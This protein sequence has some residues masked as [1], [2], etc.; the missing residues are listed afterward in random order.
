MVP[1]KD[2]GALYE[3]KRTIKFYDS[4][5]IM[6]A[7]IRYAQTG[8]YTPGHKVG[9]RDEELYFKVV[10]TTHPPTSK[11]T[12]APCHLYY[13]S[14]EQWEKHFKVSCPDKIKND[15]REKYNRA[16][17]RRMRAYEKQQA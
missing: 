6:G 14:P 4:S 1:D 12:H 17:Y 11:G 15:W 7:T 13:E 2:T 5:A 8:F 9:S 16:I 10:N 3:K